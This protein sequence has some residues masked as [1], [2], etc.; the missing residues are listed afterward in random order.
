[1]ECKTISAL[2]ANKIADAVAKYHRNR[3]DRGHHW[4]RRRADFKMKR[5]A[6][7]IFVGECALKKRASE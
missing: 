1:M 2:R 5:K 4:R 7:S 3:R 6:I